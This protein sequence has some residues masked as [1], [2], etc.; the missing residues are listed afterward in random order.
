MV[1]CFEECYRQHGHRMIRAV[2]MRRI[3]RPIARK[4]VALIVEPGTPL[5]GDGHR[6]SHAADDNAFVERVIRTIKEE[7]VWLNCYD[8]LDAYLTHYNHERP[9]SALDY[10]TPNKVATRLTAHLAA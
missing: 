3:K 9:H 10:Q 8:T 6:L 1:M 4:T 2:L 7:E 5:P